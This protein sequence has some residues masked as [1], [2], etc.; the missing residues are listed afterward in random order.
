MLRSPNK[1]LMAVGEGKNDG[2]QNRT[3]RRLFDF[4]WYLFKKRLDGWEWNY[5]L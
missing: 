1:R 4:L 5:I 3:G 2:T